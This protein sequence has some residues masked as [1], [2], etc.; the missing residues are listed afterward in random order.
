MENYIVKRYEENAQLE[1]AIKSLTNQV[2]VV[3]NWLWNFSK[4]Y[5]EKNCNDE[6]LYIWYIEQEGKILATMM[7]KKLEDSVGRIDIKL[8]RKIKCI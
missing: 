6:N 1:K 5:L 2:M 4:N 8:K 3:E 7:L